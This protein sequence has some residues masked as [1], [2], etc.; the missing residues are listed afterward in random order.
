MHAPH[1]CGSVAMVVD[2]VV[3]ICVASEDVEVVVVAVAAEVVLI[4]VATVVEVAAM[5][6]WQ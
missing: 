1:S 3:V 6:F 4:V 2:A 5:S